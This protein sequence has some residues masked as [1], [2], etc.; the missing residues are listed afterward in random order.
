[1]EVGPGLGR[2]GRDGGQTFPSHRMCS[3]IN[4][5]GGRVAELTRKGGMRSSHT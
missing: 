1:M 2:Q 4:D 5:S 3:A